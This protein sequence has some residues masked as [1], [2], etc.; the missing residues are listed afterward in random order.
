MRREPYLI[1][2]VEQI[3][4]PTLAVY[5]SIMQKNITEALTI[6]GKNIL[7]PH[8]KTCKTPEVIRL[9]Q[10]NG[11]GH[12][13]C[14]TLAETEMLGMLWAEDVLLAYQPVGTAVARLQAIIDTYPATTFSCLIDN[15]ATLGIWEKESLTTPLHVYLDLNVGMNRTGVTIDDALSLIQDCNDHRSVFLKGIHVYDGHIHD[16][17]VSR[18]KFKADK[19]F[20]KAIHIRNVAEDI[21]E[22]AMELVIG[23]TPTFP[24]YAHYENVQCSPGTFVFW[25]WG[26]SVFKDLPFT[27]AALLLTRVISIIDAKRLCLD[28]GHKAV[29]SENPLH[30]RLQF[31]NVESATLISHSEEH[32]VVEVADTAKHF[33]G[34]VWYAI[35]YH[36]CPTVAL[37]Q[38]LNVIVD[39]KCMGEWDIVARNRKINF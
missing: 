5:P 15:S 22:R 7:R 35:P 17:D 16:V 34:E 14:A 28:L 37:H 10:E 12:F 31:L 29:A 3:N 39:G 1:T 20:E 8:V 11:I 4:T 19:V 36:I 21:C 27:P 9:M 26:Y 38:A 6:A 24:M 32:L 2:H 33:L 25:D 18:R 23:G 13:K 30:N